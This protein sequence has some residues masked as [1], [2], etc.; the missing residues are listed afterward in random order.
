MNSDLARWLYRY[1]P[2][3]IL[4]VAVLAVLVVPV[5]DRATNLSASGDHSSTLS[6]RG[7]GA[8][9]PSVTFAEGAAVDANGNVVSGSSGSSGTGGIGLGTSGGGGAAPTDAGV[10]TPEALKATNCDPTTGRIKF[11]AFFREP[12]VRPWAKGANNGGATA[13]GVTA[14]T[15]TVSLIMGGTTIDADNNREEV[16]QSWKD[17]FALWAYTH[18]SYGRDY[19]L[20]FNDLGA[21]TS[22]DETQLRA[23]AVTVAAQKPFAALVLSSNPVLSTELAR[24]GIVTVGSGK[25]TDYKAFSPYLWGTGVSTELAVCRTAPYMKRLIGK[26]ARWSGNAELKVQTRKMALM[27]PDT[28]DVGTINKCWAEYGA[29]ADLT[30]TYSPDA[31]T[32]QNQVPTL[33]TKLKENNITTLL[34]GAGEFFNMKVM[35]AQMT[36]QNYFPEWVINGQAND[37]LD[38]IIRLFADPGQRRQYFGFG[39]VPPGSDPSEQWFTKDI[40]WYYGVNKKSWDGKGTS[41]PNT[42]T[43]EAQAAIL[44]GGIHMAGPRLT[45]K[46]FEA[47][48][49]ALPGFG[50]TNCKCITTS[51]M[52]SGPGI[53]P[54]SMGLSWMQQSDGNEFWWDDT[55]VG[56]DTTGLT[57]TNGMWRYMYN[58]QRSGLFEFRSSEPPAFDKTNTITNNDTQA[59]PPK[60]SPPT[61]TMPA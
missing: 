51:S 9:D 8:N 10:G 49:F 27:Y 53:L 2:Y 28:A 21:G 34:G 44:I 31:T 40:D 50:G 59:P 47:G 22:P 24:R 41:G 26:P 39:S 46:S 60:T 45:A 61:V 52:R 54:A 58:G 55:A 19:K 1:R 5:R 14:D 48:R 12:C 37:D 23:M 32:F 57:N 42:L 3:V 36:S 33:I 20:I 38:F 7:A 18:E 16:K 13:P 43:E 30:I 56:P 29:K 4:A 25:W 17:I 15:I 11:P 35:G 6:N